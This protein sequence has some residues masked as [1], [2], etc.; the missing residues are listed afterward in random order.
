MSKNQEKSVGHITNKIFI[1]TTSLDLLTL[2]ILWFLLPLLLSK[3]TLTLK[4][5]GLWRWPDVLTLYI[6]QC[7]HAYLSWWRRV[8]SYLYVFLNAQQNILPVTSNYPFGIPCRMYDVEENYV[9]LDA[10]YTKKLP[11]ALLSLSHWKK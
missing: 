2:L 7:W 6:F 3:H 9:N 1:I 4:S 5:L 8:N 11:I 10:V